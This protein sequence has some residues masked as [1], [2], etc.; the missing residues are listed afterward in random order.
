VE[1]P[2][3]QEPFSSS[4]RV[5]L[6]VLAALVGVGLLGFV[7]GNFSSLSLRGDLNEVTEQRD[8]E[9]ARAADLARELRALD[10]EIQ[11]LE[12][13]LANAQSAGPAKPR[14]AEEPES[15]KEIGE[16]HAVGTMEITPT[17]FS[18][19]S[20]DESTKTY[21]TIVSVKN[22]G[23][24]G[25]NPFCGDEGGL[26]DA[27]GRTFDP[28]TDLDYDSSNCGDDVQPGLTQTDYRLSFTL[29]AEAKPIIL[30][31][32]GDFQ[33]EATPKLWN[34]KGL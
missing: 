11:S 18:E 1:D 16:T 27:A 10:Q 7:L 24:E 21:Q 32:W 33:Y 17:S 20:A 3:T 23:S 5:P 6:G 26:V 9:S 30:S 29:P 12:N 13:R 4:R 31:L 2:E 8:N 14:N 19:L 22:T 28:N 15:L 34:V 25:I